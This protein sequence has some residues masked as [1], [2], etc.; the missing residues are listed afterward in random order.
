M[1][2]H[3]TPV[4]NSEFKTPILF[5][6]FNRPDETELV[7]QEIRSIK[8]KYLYIACD[9]PR[10]NNHK[11]ILQV[12]RV[13]AIVQNIDWK[14]ECKYLFQEENL[15]CGRGVSSA[16]DWFFREVECGIIIE[17]DCL[18]T[19]SFFLFCQEMLV[20]Y[21]DIDQVMAIAGTNIAKN[22]IYDTDYV[23][24]SFPIMWGWAT[25]RR[26][27][28]KYDYEMTEW[29]K[30]KST[31]L[32][33]LNPS[34]KWK[35]HPVYT[36]FYDK[37]FDGIQRNTLNTWDHQWIFSNWLHYGLTVTSTKNLVKNIGFGEDATHTNFDNLGRA[38]LETFV[39]S[40]PYKGP[41]SIFSD[42][43]TDLY[44]SKYW[45]T[46][47]WMFYGKI[48]LLRVNFIYRIWNFLKKIKIYV[49]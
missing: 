44:I 29:P 11:D 15:G 48:L 6:V 7:F 49:K 30:V 24:T 8:P 5:L 12:S 4:K 38:N 3:N 36:E 18:P 13:R 9:G 46:A 32:L 23:Y 43:K 19:L 20:K 21:L 35:L 31:G 33:S 47:T 1:V 45:F 25:W 17:D 34:D 2:Q 42:K 39:V 22:M 14:C 37:T 41:S 10:I 26:A 28:S 16:I 40:P 27:W